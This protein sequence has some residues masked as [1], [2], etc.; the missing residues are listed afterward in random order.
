[1]RDYR[2]VVKNGDWYLRRVDSSV[3]E[4]PFDKADF[5][6]TKIQATYAIR[7]NGDNGE[8]IKVHLKLEG[9]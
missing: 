6:A 4:V 1:M 3:Q 8:I 7:L 9:E 5:F 2:Y